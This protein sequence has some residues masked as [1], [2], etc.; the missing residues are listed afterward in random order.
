[1]IKDAVRVLGM[2]LKL[3]EV[4]RGQKALGE[5]GETAFKLLGSKNQGVVTVVSCQSNGDDSG[6]KGRNF[7]AIVFHIHLKTFRM[8]GAEYYQPEKQNDFQQNDLF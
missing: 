3:H 1:M 5:N 2:E 8:R 4:K 7:K 6:G